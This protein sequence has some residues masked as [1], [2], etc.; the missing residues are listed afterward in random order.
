MVIQLNLAARMCRGLKIDSAI[1]SCA[2]R[3]KYMETVNVHMGCR[4]ELARKVT[5]YGG[6]EWDSMQ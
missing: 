6:G 3:E 4:K 1:A 2:E 5:C